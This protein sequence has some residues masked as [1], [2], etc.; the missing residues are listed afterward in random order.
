MPQADRPS[1]TVPAAAVGFHH[2][3]PST[4]QRVIPWVQ[5]VIAVLQLGLGIDGPFPQP[6]WSLLWS[7]TLAMA[8][9]QLVA[10]RRIGTEVGPAGLRVRNGVTHGRWVAWAQVSELRAPPRFEQS[11]TARLVGGRRL[12]LR[13]LPGEVAQALIDA[14]VVRQGG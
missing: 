11:W 1:P 12:V 9:V 10:V 13:G 5:V 7:L 4:A 6:W 8:I 3:P 14:T 2:H